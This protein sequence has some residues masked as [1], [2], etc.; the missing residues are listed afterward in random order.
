MKT[1]K[2]L[3]L[4]G[5]AIVSMNAFAENRLYV[6]DFEINPGETKTIQLRGITEF[7]MGGFQ[8]RILLPEGL[9]WGKTKGKY[10]VS[11][12][13]DENEIYPSWMINESKVLTVDDPETE[14]ND[15]GALSL[16]WA[17][18][19]G[20][21]KENFYETNK[22][23]CFMELKVIAA[24][25]F[26]PSKA[27]AKVRAAAPADPTAGGKMYMYNMR[28]SDKSGS[29][30]TVLDDLPVSTDVIETIA[31]DKAVKEVKY[32]NLLGVES[33]E[34]FQGVNVVVTTYDDGT[35]ASQKV[36]K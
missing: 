26:D 25:D 33:N 12:D 27:A 16:M 30:N 34:P 15:I 32:V 14:V 21:P 7:E 8:C 29:K 6:P 24:D 18:W 35:K 2:H 1:I 9:S 10:H 31:G 28:Y 11:F 36:V 23:Y 4:A 5:L 3:L 22:D 19:T 20:D 17:K 13:D